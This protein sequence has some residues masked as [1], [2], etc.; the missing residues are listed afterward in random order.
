MTSRGKCCL[1]PEGLLDVIYALS[2][3]CLLLGFDI[4]RGGG[5]ELSSREDPPTKQHHGQNDHF[6]Y[7]ADT[8]GQKKL[9]FPSTQNAI[10]DTSWANF[11]KLP[12]ICGANCKGK[13]DVFGEGGLGLCILSRWAT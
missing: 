9:H 11:D 4:G 1:S 10:L 7:P 3:P 8:Q 13:N 6:F 2:F 5:S 12:K